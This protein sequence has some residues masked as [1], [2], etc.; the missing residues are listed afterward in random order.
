[1]PPAMC[2]DRIASISEYCDRWCERCAFTS[3]CAAYA[4][5]AALGMCGDLQEALQLAV[6]VPMAVG[7]ASPAADLEFANPTAEEQHAF[8]VVINAH[9]T[10]IRGA[11]LTKHA[12]EVAVAEHQWLHDHPAL[13]DSPDPAVGEAIAVI[14]RGSIFIGGKLARTL[15]R[16][17]RAEE[18]DGDDDPVQNDKNGSA[19][20]A[21]IVIERSE[22][23]WLTIAQATGNV[24]AADV[25]SSMSALRDEV[26]AAF[27]FARLFKRPGFDEP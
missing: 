14:L 8:D 16:A 13:R 23:A 25:A 9:L 20:I 1:M 17:D 27:P 10:E 12:M 21:L 4:V 26:E 7:A 3:R 5:Q 18:E 15:S 22:S 2:T 11:P 24:G 19:K 6:G